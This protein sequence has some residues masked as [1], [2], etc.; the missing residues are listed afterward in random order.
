MRSLLDSLPDRIARIEACGLPY[1]VVH[2]D[3]HPGNLR[4]GADP[5]VWFDWGDSV[6]GHP[7]FDLAVVGRM[8]ISPAVEASWLE[9]W[10]QAAPGSDPVTAWS[11]VR[12]LAELR[13]AIVYQTF[14]DS[15]EPS[16]RVFHLGDP[17]VALDRAAAAS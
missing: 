14:L 2:G 7:L 17:A 6:V 8:G 15:I 11:L 5:P 16:E 12:P 9:L 1:V 10:R 3:A 4:I 13:L